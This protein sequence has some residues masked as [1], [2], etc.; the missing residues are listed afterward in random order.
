MV[1]SSGINEKTIMGLVKAFSDSVAPLTKEIEIQY[2]LETGNHKHGTAWDI[3]FTRIKKAALQN[4]LVVLKLK[5]G[6]WTFVTVLNLDTGIM[7]VF[8]KEKNFDLVI[9][10][11]GKNKIHYFHAF[12]SK[13][14]DPIELD[15]HQLEFFSTISEEYEARRI[16]EVQKILGENY[17]DVKAVVFVIGKEE[18][19]KIT[20]VEA[21]LYNRY[22]QLLDIEN[23]SEFISE[24]HQYEDIFVSNEES[25]DES[26]EEWVIPTLK[27]HIKQRKHAFD[28]KIAEE[29]KDR[30]DLNEEKK[31]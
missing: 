10:N 31:S 20:E 29:K 19:G 3:R 18:N 22:F 16:E 11:F 12:V 24:D 5:R 8:S 9:K 1:I 26:V 21:R 23:W 7:Y 13:N 30:D 4:D 25:E 28:K 15:N 17:P 6:M 2:E 14:G 27:A